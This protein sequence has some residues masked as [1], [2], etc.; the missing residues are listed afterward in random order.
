MDQNLDRRPG[1]W[2]ILA[3][4]HIAPPT[5][6]E[7]A[8]LTYMSEGQ[9]NKFYEGEGESQNDAAEDPSVIVYCA[10][11]PIFEVEVPKEELLATAIN[12]EDYEPEP[13]RLIHGMRLVGLIPVSDAFGVDLL[14][15]NYVEQL[16]VN[17]KE[18]EE[19]AKNLQK[20]P[21]ELAIELNYGEGFQNYSPKF[22]DDPLLHRTGPGI[23]NPSNKETEADLADKR[24]QDQREIE[25]NEQE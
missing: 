14:V 8:P 11:K 1:K 23:K 20:T 18:K 17:A 4:R 2:I 13:T 9:A 25:L 3:L 12:A 6:Y 10:V 5:V 22:K 24:A 19:R 15:D 7:A 21:E 16:K